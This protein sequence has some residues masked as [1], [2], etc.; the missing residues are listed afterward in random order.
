[1]KKEIKHKGKVGNKNAQKN[2]DGNDVY[3]LAQRFWSM[4]EIAGFLNCHPDTISNRFLEEYQ[5][6]RESGKGTLRDY[7]IQAVKKGNVT[8]MIWLGKQY[9]GQRDKETE[10]E[11]NPAE[12]LRLKE[13]ALKQMD[14]N[15]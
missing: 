5:K 3:K 9:L 7:Q 15:F 13:I 1:M 6:G 10:T 14:D 4:T 8:M 12:V 11:L 2:I